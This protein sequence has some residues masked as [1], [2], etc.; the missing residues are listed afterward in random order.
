M[1]LGTDKLGNASCMDVAPGSICGCGGIQLVLSGRF[2][3]I[4]VGLGAGESLG[5]GVGDGLG[6]A[7]GLALGEGLGAGDV[8]G[9]GVGEGLEAGDALGLG[10][11]VG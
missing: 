5:V 9:V 7:S 1:S 3:V 10:V 2:A 8:L 11:G 4:G 6:D